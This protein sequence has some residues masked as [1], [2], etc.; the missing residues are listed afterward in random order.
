VVTSG[1]NPWDPAAS[2]FIAEEAVARVTDIFG[3][4]IVQWNQEM[5]G[6]RAAKPSIYMQIAEVTPRLCKLD[7]Y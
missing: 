2:G 1:K 4:P 3:E 7:R 6:L 5:T